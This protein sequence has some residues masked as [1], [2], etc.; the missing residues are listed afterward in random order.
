MT[1]NIKSAFNTMRADLFLSFNF[2]FKF[3]KDVP[4]YVMDPCSQS[5]VVVISGID[6]IKHHT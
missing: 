2:C 6:T 3:A 1:S 5:V 4:P